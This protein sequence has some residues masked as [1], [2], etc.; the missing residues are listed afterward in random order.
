MT[1]LFQQVSRC[2][3][4]PHF[5]VSAVM[6]TM[7]LCRIRHS[8]PPLSAALVV[9]S[10]TDAAPRMRC[11]PSRCRH[12]RCPALCPRNRWAWQSASAL[13]RRRSLTHAPWKSA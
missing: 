11:S 6:F 12:A 5:Q 3:G 1:G 2:I 10:P 4:S 8:L 13:A 7:P 9:T